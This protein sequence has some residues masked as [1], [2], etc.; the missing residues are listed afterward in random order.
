MDCRQ[1]IE[2]L[3]SYLDGDASPDVL[4]HLYTCSCCRQLVSTCQQTIRFYRAQ[5]APPLHA[6][7]HRR[8]MT[9]V[10]DACHPRPASR[11]E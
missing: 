5:P 1:L 8:L 3:C 6:D 4:Q 10:G 7:L 9:H 11:I 2:H